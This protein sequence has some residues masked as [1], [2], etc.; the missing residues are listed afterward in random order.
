[1]YA[2]PYDAWAD[3]YDAI[4][5]Y[6][7]DDIPFYLEEAATHGEGGVLELGCGTGRIAIPLALS[8]VSVTALDS[9]AD[10]LARAREK[11]AA[12]AQNLTLVQADMRDFDLRRKFSLIIIPFRGFL[13]LLSA[14]DQIAALRA[15]KRHL[16]PGGRLALDIF[17]PDLNMLVQEGDV[18]F[19]FRDVTDPESGKR[20]IIWNQSAYDAFSQVMTIR[21]SIEE[22]D[23][24]GAVRRKLYRDF[25]LRYIFRWEMSHL[26]HA[27]GY[28][29]LHLYGDFRKSEFIPESSE[30]IWIATP[31]A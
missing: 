26:L 28:D 5:S 16:L 11:S 27:C 20:L 29:I 4:F 18:P 21:T 17:V 22:L 23:D 15:I 19:H 3:I 12:A 14:D 7:V 30:M 1:M 13:S 6:V 2:S 10:M 25:A 8:G 31:S 24:D 9:S